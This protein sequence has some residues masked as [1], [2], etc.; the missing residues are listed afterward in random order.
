[1]VPH[2][3]FSSSSDLAC[4]GIPILHWRFATSCQRRR[5]DWSRQPCHR[6]TGSWR[7]CEPTIRCRR[8]SFWFGCCRRRRIPFR[9][10]GCFLASMWAAASVLAHGRFGIPARVVI[11]PAHGPGI[12]VDEDVVV[13]AAACSWKRLRRRVRC[14]YRCHHHHHHHHDHSTGQSLAFSSCRRMPVPMPLGPAMMPLDPRSGG[15]RSCPNFDTPTPAAP[16]VPPSRA[17][18]PAAFLF[19]A[20]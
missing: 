19:D 9:S 1:M 14:H 7:T 5:S 4:H 15:A 13:D 2:L 3:A 12:A 20:A 10:S 8:T 18:S 11:G 17:A 6:W 16:E